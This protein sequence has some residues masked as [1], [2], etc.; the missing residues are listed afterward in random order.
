[1]HHRGM[2]AD[3]DLRLVAALAFTIYDI[4]LTFG[5]EVE[6]IWNRPWTKLKILF[7]VL[8][9]I[10]VGA[11]VIS[12]VITLKLA[13]GATTNHRGCQMLV[14]FQGASSHALM[15]GVQIILV[16][17]VQ[18][19]Y[20]EKV[21]LRRLILFLFFAEVVVMIVVFSFA[22]PG[23]TYGIHCVTLTFPVL[24]IGFFITPVLFELLLFVLTMKKF[25]D[26][27][28][29]GWGREPV[30]SRFLKD[31]IWAF[32]LPFGVLMLNVFCL[33]LLPGARSS[34][35][36]SWLIA[37]PGFAACRL[38][39][40]M[41]HLLK[42]NRT[43]QTQSTHPVFDT[44]LMPDAFTTTNG[45]YTTN[46]STR[47]TAITSDSSELNEFE[48]SPLRRNF[49]ITTPSS[50]TAMSPAPSSSSQRL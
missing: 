23:I 36:Y 30:M 44:D 28:R 38:I 17:R 6:Q 16:L 14:G 47:F 7:Y 12:T 39:L 5:D 37:I 25:Y 20:Y 33:V 3:W 24:A 8:R 26:A 48:M 35:V 29:D 15:I 11:Q 50:T 46:Q 45:M 22:F 40:N 43:V 13:S 42:A 4:A 34:I 19:L 9:T 1:M 21:F 49:S 41:S 31:G 27:V 2:Q 32:A 18:A 10:S